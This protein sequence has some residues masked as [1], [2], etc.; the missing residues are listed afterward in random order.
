M[1]P[2]RVL[3]A[4]ILV[5]LV[6]PAG[7]VWA[8]EA[9][10]GC[11]KNNNGQ[12][13]LVAAGEACLPSEH[14]VQWTAGSA[15]PTLP[16]AA[17]GPLRVVDQNDTT[18]G[19]F[20]ATAMGTAAARQ[21]GDLWLALPVLPGG[22]QTTN[23]VTFMAFYLDD[24]CSSDPYLSVDTSSL[25]R[26]GFVMP[27]AAG[28]AFSYPG[29]PEVDRTAIHGYARWVAGTWKCDS[30]TPAAWMPLFGKVGTLDLST[31]QAPFKI[32]Q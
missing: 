11:A 28:L 8:Q 4:L 13:R 17:P 16:A 5:V 2:T 15:E 20:T 21:V 19:L 7:T 3:V 22:F 18:L 31:F 1:R 30:Y 29:T 26:G 23:P 10:Y 14:P 6:F 27:G 25:L 24:Q 12:L 9:I 32:V